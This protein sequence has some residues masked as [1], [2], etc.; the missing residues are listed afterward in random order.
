MKKSIYLSLFALCVSSLVFAQE[1]EIGDNIISGRIGIGS[2]F[3]DG[4]SGNPGYS[5]DYERGIWD[6]GEDVISLGGYLGVK[7][8]DFNGIID[9]KATYTIIGVRGAYHFNSLNLED[10]DI[11]G[12]AMVSLNSVSFSGVGNTLGSNLGL[13]I[14]GGG[15]YYFSDNWAA[16]VELGYGVAFVNLGVSY[17]L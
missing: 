10:F 6:V 12:G 7:T 8:F 15:R 5:I 2:S 4:G 16:S 14:F 1:F 11:Y 9:G 3:G 13:T 17:K